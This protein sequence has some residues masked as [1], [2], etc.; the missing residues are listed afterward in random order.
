MSELEKYIAEPDEGYEFIDW[1]AEHTEV[2]KTRHKVPISGNLL[3]VPEMARFL[4]VHGLT[5]QFK[6]FSSD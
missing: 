1:V 3:M 4:V 6:Q 2:L 5:E